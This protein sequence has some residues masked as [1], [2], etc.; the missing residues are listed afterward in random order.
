MK[1]GFSGSR[2][3]VVPPLM[4]RMMEGDPLMSELHITD[5]GYYPHASHHEISRTTPISQ[6]VIIYC[7]EGSGQFWWTARDGVRHEHQVG[8]NQYFILPARCPHGYTASKEHPWTIYWIHFDGRLASYYGEGAGQPVTVRPEIHSRI[9]SRQNLFEEI[10]NVLQLGFTRENLA[11]SS[12][13]LHYYL[14]SLRFVVQYRLSSAVNQVNPQNVVDAV[15][16]YMSENIEKHLTLDNL[17]AY[18]GYSSSHLS[19]LFRSATGHSPLEH[20]NIMKIKAACQLLHDTPMRV[21]QICHKVG[22]TDC[23]YF[24]RLFKKIVGVPPT[25]YRKDF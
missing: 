5:I 20:F 2:M 9:S 25:E 11:Y 6:Y 15:I 22:F 14:G 17:C 7:V 4:L 23:Y 24:S 21:N 18:A 10:F 1:D 8:A 16:H 19:A 12:S 3:L 13:L